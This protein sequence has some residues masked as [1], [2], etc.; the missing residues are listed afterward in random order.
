MNYYKLVARILSAFLIVVIGT[1]MIAELVIEGIPSDYVFTFTEK[2]L[3]VFLFTSFFGLIIAWRNEAIG[4]SLTVFGVTLFMLINSIDIGEFRF[5]PT[6]ASILLAGIL[7][8]MSTRQSK[9][10]ALGEM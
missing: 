3:F 4:G 8:L 7:F 10:R 6:F 1:I 5:N 9:K 2:M